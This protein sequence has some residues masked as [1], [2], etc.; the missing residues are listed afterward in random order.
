MSNFRTNVL[1][2]LG[3]RKRETTPLKGMAGTRQHFIVSPYSGKTGI[4]VSP[5]TSLNMAAVYRAVTLLVNTCSPLP[6]EKFKI[7]SNGNRTRDDDLFTYIINYRPNTE[8]NALEYNEVMIANLLLRGNCYAEKELNVLGETLNYWPI[9]AQYC[10]PMRMED[11]TIWLACMLPSGKRVLL[12]PNKYLHIKDFSLDGMLGLSRIALGRLSIELGLSQ[13]ALGISLMANDAKVTGVLE[14]PL[15]MTEDDAEAFKKEWKSEGQALFNKGRTVIL[16]KGM[17][18]KPISLSPKDTE[19]IQSRQFQVQEIAR[20]FSVPPHM[21]YD[22][23]RSTYSNI[24]QQSQ[25]F[26]IYSILP[27][28][29]RFSVAYLYDQYIEKDLVKLIQSKMFRLLVE[30]AYNLDNLL[31]A[32]PLTQST[33]FTNLTGIGVN[34]PNDCLKA[35]KRPSLGKDGDI[36]TLMNNRIPLDQVGKTQNNGTTKQPKGNTVIPDGTTDGGTGK[37]PK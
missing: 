16:E 5:E 30:L 35:M 10:T 14:T 9:P 27:I 32:D 37:P 26:S 3:F 4:Y 21:L 25:E 20:W 28:L 13:E 33:I 36:R 7:D 11:N 31:N 18:F 24:S 6:L 12:P 22:L 1:T 15:E 2:G 17:A 23:T 19:F 29:N 8:M 34:S